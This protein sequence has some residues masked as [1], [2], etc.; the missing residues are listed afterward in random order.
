MDIQRAVKD[1]VGR[2]QDLYHR[3][4]SD[5]D[6]L[7]D[8]DLVTLREQLHILDAEAGALQDRKDFES[9]GIR[10]IFGGRKRQ[11]GTALVRRKAA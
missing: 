4:R 9:D 2:G 10:F 11:D 3:L 7:S 1:F 5:G 6:S 8:F